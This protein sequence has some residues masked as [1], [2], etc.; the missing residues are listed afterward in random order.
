MDLNRY[1]EFTRTTAIYPDAGTGK[2]PELMYLAL[3]L[4]GEA[5]EVANK[6]KKLF[7]DGDS[8]EKRD[9]LK[10]EI[11]DVFWYLARLCDALDLNPED[12]LQANAD[13]L[14]S[15]KE[16]GVIGGSGDER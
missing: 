12:I 3:G 15:R 14:S 6:V 10:G 8:E 16:R 7:R 13:K 5:G 9:R 11:G 4:A 2:L 1:K